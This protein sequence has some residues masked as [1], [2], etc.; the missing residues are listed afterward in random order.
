MAMNEIK[1]KSK[2][3]RR[4]TQIS[5][6]NGL[7]PTYSKQTILASKGSTVKAVL[8]RVEPWVLRGDVDRIIQYLL[9]CA[10]NPRAGQQLEGGYV[11]PP[12]NTFV[13]GILLNVMMEQRAGN[14]KWLPM[15]ERVGH[16]LATEKKA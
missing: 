11:V 10:A 15:L 1:A 4:E 7:G 6:L 2:T 8:Q 16:M 13:A 5:D 3:T 9:K 14:S 12:F